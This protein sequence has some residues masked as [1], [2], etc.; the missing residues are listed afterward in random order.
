M[1]FVKSNTIIA[2]FTEFAY[3]FVIKLFIDN[4]ELENHL[5]IEDK[6]LAQ[7]SSIVFRTVDL[8]PIDASNPLRQGFILHATFKDTSLSETAAY[9]ILEKI[10]AGNFKYEYI[11]N[12]Q[13]C[14]EETTSIENE[15]FTWPKSLIG[16]VSYIRL[17]NILL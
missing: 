9:N 10:V 8:L 12:S 11:L 5:T 15:T 3:D 13:L 14:M 17:T 6:L 4:V 7:Q 1:N 2:N 16:T